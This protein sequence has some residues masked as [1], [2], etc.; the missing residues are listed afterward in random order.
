MCPVKGFNGEAT[1]VTEVPGPVTR[2][3]MDAYAELV[4]YDWMGQY[5]KRLED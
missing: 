1:A 5:L 2:R 3:L 4:D